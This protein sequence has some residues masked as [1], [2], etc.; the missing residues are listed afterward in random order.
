MNPLLEVTFQYV[1]PVD[2]DAATSML[3]NLSPADACRVAP[4]APYSV[5]TNVLHAAIWQDQWL[6]FIEETT[7][8]GESRKDWP[9]VTEA[10]WP[11]VQSRFLE[12]MKRAVRLASNPDLS[13][14]QQ[15]RVVR[16]AIHGAYHLGQISLLT[17]MVK[18]N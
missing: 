14:D 6:A 5:A 4:G 9:D 1:E 10:E 12:G 8:S 2:F 3:A 16:I 17:Q 18:P 13:E 15:R 7:P 11:A